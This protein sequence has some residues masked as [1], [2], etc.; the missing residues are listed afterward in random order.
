VEE[1]PISD[2]SH[3]CFDPPQRPSPLQHGQYTAY[4]DRT[5]WIG[6]GDQVYVLGLVWENILWPQ[7]QNW[8]RWGSKVVGLLSDA[9]FKREET[10]KLEILYFPIFFFGR[11]WGGRKLY[12]IL[13]PLSVPHLSTVRS[14]SRP[15]QQ[16]LRF[17]RRS[18]SR[19]SC[20]LTPLTATLVDTLNYV[21]IQ[22]RNLKKGAQIPGDQIF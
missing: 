4:F 9:E 21:S 8:Q 6:V 2:F 15:R 10:G 3:Q 14:A 1:H 11:P 17:E 19:S 16:T 22:S 13:G 18:G 7:H 20:Y 5:G 12:F